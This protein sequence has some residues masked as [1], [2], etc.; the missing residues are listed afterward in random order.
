MQ[1]VAQTQSEAHLVEE[2]EF[3]TKL[4]KTISSMA[5]SSMLPEQNLS[6]ITDQLISI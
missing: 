4:I 3:K 5:K 1:I 2:L 6:K